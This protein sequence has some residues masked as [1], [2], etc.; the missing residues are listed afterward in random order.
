[1][2]F[3]GAEAGSLLFG[4]VA[5]HSCAVWS[6]LGVYAIWFHRRVFVILNFLRHPELVSGSPG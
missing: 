6:I 2:A 4:I 5:S 3:F 1:M